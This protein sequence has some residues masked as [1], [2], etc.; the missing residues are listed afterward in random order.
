MDFLQLAAARYSVRKFQPKPVSEEHI[1]SILKA[2]HLAPTACNLQPQRILV[3]DGKEEL[4]KLKR[5]TKCH[6]DAPAAFLVC[7]EKDA[8]WQRRYD[9]K[10]SG[11]VDASI[12]T[13]HMMLAAASLGVGTTWVMS[14]DPV[15][16]RS[17]FEVP[18]AFEPVVIL[19][20]GYPAEDAAPYPGH[21][22]FRPIEQTVFRNR[23]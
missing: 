13:T 6:F 15:A 3:I 8:C 16:V 19:V 4:E 2:G 10:R 5:C 21:S 11:E 23:F 17:E 18:E 22:E 7:Y 12:V 9:G 20:A 1:S 14:F